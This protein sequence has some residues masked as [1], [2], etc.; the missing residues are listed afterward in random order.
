M[1]KSGIKDG[2]AALCF[3]SPRAHMHTQYMCHAGEG[4]GA[5]TVQPS[6]YS[7]AV[8]VRRSW[9]QPVYTVWLLHGVGQLAKKSAV[10]NSLSIHAIARLRWPHTAAWKL[11]SW[12][13]E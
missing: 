12:V 4:G 8:G 5:E 3:K 1:A 11:Q 6:E 7:H 9:R 10:M 13:S 2:V